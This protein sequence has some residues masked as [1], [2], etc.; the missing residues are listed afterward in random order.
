MVNSVIPSYCNMQKILSLFRLRQ[1]E[2]SCKPLK[3]RLTEGA[4]QQRA[5]FQGIKEFHSIRPILVVSVLEFV[6][7]LR[8]ILATVRVMLTS[9]WKLCLLEH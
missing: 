6:S 5:S 1:R 2:A 3:I 8:I 7:S 4:K 9:H